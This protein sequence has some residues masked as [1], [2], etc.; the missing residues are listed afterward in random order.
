MYK[1][2]MKK[3][4]GLCMWEDL[5]EGRGKGLCYNY[6]IISKKR[7]LFRTSKKQKKFEL[8][9]PLPF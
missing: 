9:L 2:K 4:K 3:R 7:K 6:L 1:K 8:T 5:K